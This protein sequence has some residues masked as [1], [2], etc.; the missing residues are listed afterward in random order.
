MKNRGFTLIEFIVIISIFAVMASVALFNFNGFRS[1]IGLNNLAHDIGLTIRQAQVF[2][3]AT[4]SSDASGVLEIDPV[5]GN[6]IRYADGVY[7]PLPVVGAEYQFLLYQKSDP[8]DTQNYV[9]GVD[10]IV[11]TIKVA[12]PYTIDM[13]LSSDEKRDLLITSSRTVPSTGV[14]MPISNVSI[15][16]SRPR[17]EALFFH[18]A[19]IDNH[20]YIGIYVR[21]SSDPTGTANHV[22]IVSRNGEI[23]V[24]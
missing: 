14:T 10:T 22:I 19:I 3:W 23:D 17:P 20:R 12:G 8:R 7:F 1:N 16:F 21:N 5:T 9:A 6:P 24:Q 4:Q 18:D 15:A 11:D 2:G 13:I